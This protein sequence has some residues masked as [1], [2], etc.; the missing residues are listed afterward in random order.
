MTIFLYH[1]V[2]AK[3]LP[4]QKPHEHHD[5]T[6]Q[7]HENADAIDSMHHFQVD[8][9]A[10]AFAKHGHRIKISKEAFNYHNAKL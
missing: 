2:A 4:T 10:F 3:G 9:A 7:K 8:I 5:H 6:N 1:T